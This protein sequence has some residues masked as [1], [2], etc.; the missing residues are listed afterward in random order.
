ME[1]KHKQHHGEK[2]NFQENRNKSNGSNETTIYN[3]VYVFATLI[4][5][6][7]KEQASNQNVPME[8]SAIFQKAN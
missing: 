1:K 3:S 5:Q 6:G 7:C 8:S 4:F 2:S